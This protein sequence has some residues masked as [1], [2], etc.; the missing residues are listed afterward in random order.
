VLVCLA[1]W[2]SL[3]AHRDRKVL[4]VLFRLG[5]RGGASALGANSTSSLGL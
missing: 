1:V 5:V 3:G 2:L 4:A